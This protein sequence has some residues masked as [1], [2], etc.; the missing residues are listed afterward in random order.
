MIIVTVID[1]KNG[2]LF[3][4]RRQSQ[5]REL[6]KKIE[7]ISRKSK[8][9]MNA[10]SAGQFASLPENAIV[11]EDFL[12]EADKGDFCFVED[13]PLLSVKNRIEAMVLFHWNRSYPSDFS[14][15]FIPAGQGMRLI[16]TEDFPGYSHENITM[17][18]WK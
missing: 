18:V 7:Q 16:Q 4:H 12:T 8:L 13:Q 6:R 10:F 15:D 3:N 17:E 1:D 2:L 14:L 5:D 11:S 9:W